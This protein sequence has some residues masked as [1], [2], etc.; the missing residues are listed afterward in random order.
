[1]KLKKKAAI[2]NF[3]MGNLNSV[4]ISL[5]YLAIEN[6]ILDN[7]QNISDYSHIVLPGVGSF[8]KAVKNLQKNGFFDSLLQVSKNKNQ[9]ILGICLGMQLLF[10]SST[11][12]GNSKGLGILKGKVEKFSFSKIKNIKIPHVGFNQVLFN[13]KNSFY[14]DI[15]LNSDFYF[16]HS[17]CVKNFSDDLN[18]GATHYGE[19]FLSS[20]N[21]D[22]I[23][24]TQF[25]PEKSQS[26]GLLILRNF[27]RS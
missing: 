10:E 19:R 2:I 7:P 23:F 16:D 21:K 25:H 11:E 1:M 26:N 3:G 5:N 9:K 27:L 14:K 17:Y 4:K 22:N 13:K 24:G 18:S 20:F 8:K 12:E 6:E 15:P